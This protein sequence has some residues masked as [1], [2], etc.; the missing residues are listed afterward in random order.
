MSITESKSIGE[1]KQLLADEVFHHIGQQIIDGVLPPQ[2]R[3]RDV[4]VAEE[5]HVSRTPVREALQRLERLGLVIMYPSRYTEVTIV[6]EEIVE[7]TRVFAGY[8]A[9]IS[10]RMGLPRI[11]AI[12]RT[13]L[14]KLVDDMHTALEGDE[15]TSESR[16]AVFSYL[17][18]H[19]GNTQHMSLMN[20]AEVALFRNLRD[21]RVPRDDRERMHTT[22]ASFRAAILRG[23]ADE[24]ERLARAMYYV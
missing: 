2:H 24:A 7:Q 16:W 20:D 19:S 6:T 17:S 9:G 11:T 12:Q 13:H 3:I 1:S 23:D 22:Y 4:E 8:Q 14:A 5:F 21:W 18:D 10:A 15:G